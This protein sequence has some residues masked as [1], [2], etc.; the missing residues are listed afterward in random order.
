VTLPAH[1]G[2]VCAAHIHHVNGKDHG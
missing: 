1:I 2:G